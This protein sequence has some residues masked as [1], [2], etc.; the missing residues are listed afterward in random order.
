MFG[1]LR[2]GMLHVFVKVTL[3]TAARLLLKLARAFS[4]LALLLLLPLPFASAILGLF[5]HMTFQWK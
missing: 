2:V 5:L 4:S 1:N 3:S